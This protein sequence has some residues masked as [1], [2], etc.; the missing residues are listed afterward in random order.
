LESRTFQDRTS[1][2]SVSQPCQRTHWQ[3]IAR[4]PA[5]CPTDTPGQ[6]VA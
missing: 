3:K 2:K 6:S 5:G 4:A 1:H